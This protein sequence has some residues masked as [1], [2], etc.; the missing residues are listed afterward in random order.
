MKKICVQNLGMIIT[1][2]CNLNCRHCLRGC[3]NNSDMSEDVIK[4]TLDQIKGITNLC[5]CGGEPTLALEPLEI[6]F[7]Y[8]IKS[9]IYLKGVTCVINGTNYSKN[10]LELLQYINDYIS[11]FKK[12]VYFNIS[13]DDYHIEEIK[14]LKMEKRFLENLKKYYNSSFFND[15]QGLANPKLFKEG[16]AEKLD[17]NKTID[18]IPMKNYITYVGKLHKFDRINGLCNIGPIVTIN[19]EGIITECDASIIN[20]YNKYNYGN[21]LNDSIEEV[22]LNK[23]DIVSLRDWSYLIDEEISKHLTYQK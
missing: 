14:R 19:T 11:I 4:A 15:F 5:I 21:V 16:N 13:Y 12:R 1:N 17:S 2:K 6:L 23:Y 3:K 9:N 10:F 22:M 18:L 20:Q 7:D 8:I